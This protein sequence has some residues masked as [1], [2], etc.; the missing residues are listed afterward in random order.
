M[1][2]MILKALDEDGCSMTDLAQSINLPVDEVSGLLFKYAIVPRTGVQVNRT[3]S[4]SKSR[5]H[6]RVVK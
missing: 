5:S 3:P 4:H 6:L 1:I 2:S